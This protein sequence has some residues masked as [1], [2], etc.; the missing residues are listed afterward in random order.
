MS[1]PKQITLPII[2]TN[3]TAASDLLQG[4]MDAMEAVDDAIVAMRKIEFNA[5]D[6]YCSP[7]PQ[8]WTKAVAE[9][10]DRY[11]A[12]ETVRQELETIAG[13]VSDFVK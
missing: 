12:L 2:H 7:D 5:R 1:E 13:H 8:A 11:Q 4:Y 6:Y 3:G 10:R 9:Q